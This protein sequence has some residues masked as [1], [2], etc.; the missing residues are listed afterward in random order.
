MASFIEN[1]TLIFDCVELFK[2][3]NYAHD[4]EPDFILTEF[5]L[6]NK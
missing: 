5:L 3:I 4:L 6:F 1:Y 2:F